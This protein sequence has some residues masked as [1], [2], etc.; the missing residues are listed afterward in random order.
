MKKNISKLL[1]MMALIGVLATQMSFVLLDNFEEISFLSKEKNE[2]E[3]E[4]NFLEKELFFLDFTAFI[5]YSDHNDDVLSVKHYHYIP[6]FSSSH[7]EVI[8]PPPDVV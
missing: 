8:A 1:M 3:S 6:S 4:K 7:F 5:E 2:D